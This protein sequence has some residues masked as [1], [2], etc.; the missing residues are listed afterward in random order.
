MRNHPFV[1]V[2]K[3]AALVA[4]S[5]ICALAFLIFL[6]N[7]TK[8][9]PLPAP[10]ILADLQKGDFVGTLKT[11][12]IIPLGHEGKPDR[13]DQ[14]VELFSPVPA[15]GETVAEKKAAQGGRESE[16]QDFWSAQWSYH[17]ALIFAI[18]CGF[19]GF[20]I[21]ILW[22]WYT[23]PGGFIFSTQC[24]FDYLLHDL[25]RKKER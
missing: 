16:Q 11:S 23:F 8:A 22:D 12:G 17:D 10:Q 25:F 24:L 2:K 14:L 18:F 19:T 9:F 4:L 6:N 7:P 1:L 15:Y 20:L 21:A 5:I 13:V 3:P